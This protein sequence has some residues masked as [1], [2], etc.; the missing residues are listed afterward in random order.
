MIRQ[1]DNKI[2]SPGESANFVSASIRF[3]RDMKLL[4]RELMLENG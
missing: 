2:I 4:I 3:V 1:I